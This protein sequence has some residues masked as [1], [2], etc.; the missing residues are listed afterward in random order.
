MPENTPSDTVPRRMAGM[1]QPDDEARGAWQP[2]DLAAL[3]RHQLA[4]TIAFDLA[5]TSAE[6]AEL[7]HRIAP[8]AGIVTFGDLLR[9]TAPPVSLLEVVKQFAKAHYRNHESPLP[10]EISMTLYYATLSAAWVRHGQRITRL[11]DES[12]RGGVEKVLACPW[13]DAETRQLLVEGKWKL[14]QP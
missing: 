14:P 2:Q 11:A 3:W 4:T 10:Q 6:L 13:L 8:P 12:F 7:F 9:H 5:G 1:L